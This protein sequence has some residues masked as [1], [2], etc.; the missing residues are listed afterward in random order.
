MGVPAPPPDLTAPYVFVSYASADR[1]RVMPVV[2]ALRRAG[3]PVWLDQHAIA[4][5]ENYALEIAD[6]IAG[7][8][9][10]VLLCSAASLASRN[11][12]QEIAL[13]WKY[14]RPYLPLLLEPVAIPRDIE[15]WL[16]AAQ[17]I[18]VLDTPEAHWLPQIVTA[19][20]P[21]GITPVVESDAPPLAGREREQEILRRHLATTRV[22]SGSLALIGGEAGIGKTTLAEAL[23]HE[24]ARQG[25]IVLEGH[26]FD[27]AETPP[28]GPWIDLFAHLPV[29]A[30]LPLLPDA[31]AQRG[32]VG[33]VASQ[34]A[35]F[36]AVEDFFRAL[37]SQRPAV[38]LLDDLHWSD[39]AS[40]DLL[41]FLARS[42]A[43]LPLLILI[44]YRSDEL[45]RKHPLFALLPQLAR[46]TAVERLDLTRLDDAAVQALVAARYA[47]ADADASRL[48]AYLQV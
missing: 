43:T 42:L 18:E 21:L 34:M 8:A 12:K 38:L 16:E 11:V 22:G 46:D 27:L 25:C 33:A 40:L 17:W 6:A 10:L 35:L 28:Y 32:T 19:L 15:Y 48:V 29:A 4:G 20:A 30:A 37:T 24:A 5:G 1:D 31:F 7:C 47:L 3:V 14:E 9:A 13:A 26:C 44:T 36:V 45:T 41:R 39:P 2:A 23:L